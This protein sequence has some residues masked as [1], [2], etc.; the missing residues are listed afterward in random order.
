MNIQL[1]CPIYTY[2]VKTVTND[3]YSYKYVNVIANVMPSYS[4]IQFTAVS[5]FILYVVTCIQ[6]CSIEVFA[7][8][9]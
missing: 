2:S 1:V 8:Q 6:T 7:P 9:G 4:L 3:S 5:L